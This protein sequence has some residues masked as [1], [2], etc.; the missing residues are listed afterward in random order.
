MKRLLVLCMVCKAICMAQA[1]DINSPRIETGD[2]SY[3]GQSVG[4]NSSWTIPVGITTTVGDV[5]ANA[6]GC[7]E[8]GGTLSGCANKAQYVN[9]AGTYHVLSGGVWTTD[10]F[11]LT[12]GAV[13]EAEDFEGVVLEA[14][15]SLRAKQILNNYNGKALRFVFNGT[16]AKIMTSGWGNTLFAAGGEYVLE[17]RNN[18]PIHLFVGNQQGDVAASST[19]ITFKGASD[20]IVESASMGGGSEPYYANLAGKLTYANSGNLR[21][22]PSG[23][24]TLKSASLLP[25]G[26]G[27]GIV[28]MGNDYDNGKTFMRLDL[29]GQSS[30]VNGIVAR[31]QSIITN[32]SPNQSVL[33]FGADDLDMPLSVQGFGGDIKIVKDGSGKLSSTNVCNLTD[34]HI[35]D[36]TLGVAGGDLRVSGTLTLEAGKVLEIDGVTVVVASFDDRGGVIRKLNGGKFIL[37][38]R[39]VEDT[40]ANGDVSPWQEDGIVKNGGG[41]LTYGSDNI[42]AASF[43]HVS[44]GVLRFAGMGTTNNFWRYTI[45]GNADGLAVNVGPLRLYDKSGAFTDGGALAVSGKTTTNGYTFDANVQATDLQPRHITCSRT[46]PSSRDATSL[47]NCATTAQIIYPAPA[48]TL[49]NVATWITFTYRIPSVAQTIS[50]YDLRTQWG[51]NSQKSYPNSWRLECSPSGA[52][53]TWAVFGEE[54]EFFTTT[55]LGGQRWYH[56]GNTQDVSSDPFAGRLAQ[57]A[58]AG[59]ASDAVVRVDQGAVLDSSLVAGGQ[60]VENLEVDAQSGCGLLEGVRFAEKGVLRINNVSPAALKALSLHQLADCY[61][62]DRISGWKLLVNGREKKGWG[63]SASDDRLTIVPP[64]MVISFR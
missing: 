48:P 30:W 62:T 24:V 12:Y 37:E 14:G 42:W 49:E 31:G 33:T 9:G 26:M 56:G 27:K 60:L 5:Y 29:N 55:S 17:G 25:S 58:G 15:A 40:V 8:I 47:L 21:L 50:G 3:V 41:A 46:D 52:D 63:M 13:T 64:G 11:K 57:V 16:D 20:V 36:G 45:K 2:A 38:R 59:F 22:E 19:K 53:G 32:S 10:A 28:L 51:G 35:K 18:A 6:G 61:D 1:L 23:L 39:T 54:T 43:V 34:L 7:I 44:E 4:V